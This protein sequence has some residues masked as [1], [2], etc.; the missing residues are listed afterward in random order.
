[1]L[2]LTLSSR[3]GDYNVEIVAKIT[4]KA[5]ATPTDMLSVEVSTRC[6]ASDVK[7]SEMERDINNMTFRLVSR[8]KANQ[9]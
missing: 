5:S 2:F 1:M 3:D 7:R 6:V 9:S 8:N 4:K